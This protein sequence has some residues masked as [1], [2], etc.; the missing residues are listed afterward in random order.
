MNCSGIDLNMKYNT[1]EFADLLR[2]GKKVVDIFSLKNKHLAVVG[3]VYRKQVFLGKIS[4]GSCCTFI[5][6]FLCNSFY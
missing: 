2:H 3:I 4:K 1:A 5:L 6:S